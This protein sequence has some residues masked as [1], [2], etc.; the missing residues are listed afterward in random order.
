MNKKANSRT[1]T[2]NAGNIRLFRF[3][4]SG[5]LRG[6]KNFQHLFE[7]GTSLR[8][9]NIDLKFLL[10]PRSSEMGKTG[11]AGLAT[12]EVST[13]NECK[14]GFVVGKRLG[15]A[16]K[17]NRLRRQL[18][19]AY[20]LN[21]GIVSCEPAWHAVLIAKKIEVTYAAIE[22]DCVSLLTR[23]SRRLETHKSETG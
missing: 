18:K 23:F 22:S 9:R 7:H 8:G 1:A 4:K 14:I 5:I 21:R 20:R 6:E 11:Q 17:R 3:P 16:V 12:G 19:E 15:K 13:Q 2:G 10:L